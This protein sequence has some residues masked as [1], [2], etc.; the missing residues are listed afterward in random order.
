MTRSS[1]EVEFRD[2]A[3]GM[4]EVI[5]IRRILQ[6]LKVSEAL[7]MKLYCDYKAGISIA[8]NLVL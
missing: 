5:W 1:A 7:P 8:H 3:Q 2:V 6:E 4:C